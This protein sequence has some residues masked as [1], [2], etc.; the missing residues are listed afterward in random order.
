MS[1]DIKTKRREEKGVKERMR[2][3]GVVEG[4]EWSR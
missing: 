1:D 2:G 4:K 3:A